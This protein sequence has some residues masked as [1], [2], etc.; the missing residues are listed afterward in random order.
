MTL[1]GLDILLAAHKELDTEC[2]NRGDRAVPGDW[3]C[4]NPFLEDL[5]QLPLGE[6]SRKELLDYYFQNDS[7]RLSNLIRAFHSRRGENIAGQAVFVGA[8]MTPLLTAHM[9]MLKSWG[10]TRLHY[11]RPLYYTYYYLADL[12]GIELIPVN[13]G[14][15]LGNEIDELRLPP[16]RSPL[17]LCCPRWFMGKAVPRVL[18]QQ[19]HEW[20]Q[21]WGSPV[22]VDGAFQ[23]MRFGSAN[24]AE[25]TARLDPSLTIRSICPTKAVVAH[26]VRFSY[27]LVP[28]RWL[29]DFRYAYANTSGSG[30]SYDALAGA[31]IMQ[32]LGSDRSNTE[33]LDYIATRRQIIL[34]AGLAKDPFDADSGYFGFVE[35]PLASE[36]RV[37]KM[38][39][40]FFDIDDCQQFTRMNWLM[41]DR[42][43]DKLTTIVGRG[44]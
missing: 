41:V 27:S 32:S 13:G 40:S 44:L 37:I 10:Y 9:A 24:V 15:L 33:L 23:Y 42:E 30:C 35:L 17:L 19:I 26:G 43:F 21:K 11:V 3:Y 12:L 36:E 31:A 18:I 7:Q 29:E 5:L 1:A 14:A 25:E 34:D 20:Q 6:P 8:G 28:H 2:R 22:V 39:P 4:T 38:G 16:E